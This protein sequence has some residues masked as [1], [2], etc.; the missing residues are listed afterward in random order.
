VPH[1]RTIIDLGLKHRKSTVQVAAA[2]ALAEV[3][4]LVDCSAV[5]QRYVGIYRHGVSTGVSSCD[6]TF[7]REFRSGTP[8]MQQSL[9]RLLGVMDYKSHS[10]ALTEAI[11]CLVASITPSV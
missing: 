2:S 3:S 9:A 7:V 10:H 1:W 6:Y 4:K 8:L 11:D 5:V